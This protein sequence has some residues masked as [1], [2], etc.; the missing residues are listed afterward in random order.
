MTHSILYI[1]LIT[2]LKLNC[3]VEFCSTMRLHVKKRQLMWTSLLI[4]NVCGNYLFSRCCIVM[5]L[6]WAKCIKYMQNNSTGL[7]WRTTQN[8]AT[9]VHSSFILWH[10]ILQM[11]SGY[12]KEVCPTLKT[13]QTT[14]PHSA[15]ALYF[16]SFFNRTPNR[17]LEHTNYKY[18]N[19][20]PGF[21]EIHYH[22]KT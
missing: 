13:I 10:F 15:G 12:F 17:S 3:T 18:N 11:Q 21:A 8:T 6:I 5:E 20:N 19:I 4:W 7:F 9:L 16:I 22:C 14:I 1:P 2:K